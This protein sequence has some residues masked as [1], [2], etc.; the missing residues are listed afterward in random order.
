MQGCIGCAISSAASPKRAREASAPAAMKATSREWHGACS[1]A[2]RPSPLNKANAISVAG[3]ALKP[4]VDFQESDSIL[5]GV[6]RLFA[7]FRAPHFPTMTSFFASHDDADMADS[8]S[9][10]AARVSRRR[11]TRWRFSARGFSPTAFFRRPCT[12]ERRRDEPP[13]E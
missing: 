10:A 11:L 5:G 4:R 9:L 8:S 2:S 6:I 12:L 7:D 1:A 3:Y 13:T